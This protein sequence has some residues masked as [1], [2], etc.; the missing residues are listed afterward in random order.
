[1]Q[2]VSAAYWL[3]K[4]DRNLLII[5]QKQATGELTIRSGTSQWRLC[6]FLGQLFYAIGE[7]HRVRRWQR[8]LK[9]HCP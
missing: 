5:N 6:F 4:L 1:M 2:T 8:A 7:N 3:S 9:R